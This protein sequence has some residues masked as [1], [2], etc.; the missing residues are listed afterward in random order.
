MT[1]D[2]SESDIIGER[3][4]FF[5][6]SVFAPIRNRNIVIIISWILQGI[7]HGGYPRER[8]YRK[9]KGILII[10][11]ST[12]P[13]RARSS[14]INAWLGGERTQ[15][16]SIRPGSPGTRPLLRRTLLSALLFIHWLSRKNTAIFQE[17]RR[18]RTYAN[19]PLPVVQI[20]NSLFM[21]IREKSRGSGGKGKKNI[22]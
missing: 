10:L 6:I 9:K 1:R 21:K 16:L 19:S 4:F 17:F 7:D 15:W 13:N 11:G 2:A 20:E 8:S 14:K 5:V 22:P 12:W 3:T 18:S